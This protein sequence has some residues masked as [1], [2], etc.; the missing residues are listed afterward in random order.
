LLLL[1]LLLEAQ[2]ELL[3]LLL[4]E[5]REELLLLFLLFRVPYAA[6]QRSNVARNAQKWA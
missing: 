2:E 5:A 3:L 6:L 1:L 4:L